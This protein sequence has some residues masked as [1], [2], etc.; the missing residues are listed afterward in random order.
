MEKMIK[1]KSLYTSKSISI[2]WPE[3]YVLYNGRKPYPDELILK[4]S[5]LFMK[6]Q[7]LGLPEK[8]FPLL[9]LKVKVLNINEGKNTNI[10]KRCSKL[11]EYSA[12][13]TKTN[14]YL[15]TIDDKEKAVEESIK[16]CQKHDILKEFLEIHGSE[17]F[18]M[19]LEEWNMDDAKV[20]WQEEAWEEG[21]EE[22]R[23]EEKQAIARN[24]LAEGSTHEFIQKIT[25]L[26]IDEIAKL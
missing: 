21:H 15:K 25:G 2:P 5:D 11:A 12:F 20:V 13:V 10:V 17:V 6:P 8:T 24:L 23:I 16:Y 9:E 1:G 3:F 14:E 22:G 26:S 4:L 18:N 19:I 7:E